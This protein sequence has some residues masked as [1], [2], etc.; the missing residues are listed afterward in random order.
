M[1]D[2]AIVGSGPA[3]LSAA[4]YAARAGLEVKVFEK[5]KFGGALTEIAKIEN[6]PGFMGPGAEL[7]EKLKEQAE[8]AG[9]KFAYGEL[10][11]ISESDNHILIKIDD[12]DFDTHSVLIATGSEPRPLSFDPKIPVSYCALCDAPLYKGKNIAV[13]G[14]GNSA[15]GESIYL[16]DIVKHLTIFSHTKISAEEYLIEKLKQHQNVEIKEAVEP[17]EELLNNFDG[18][19]VFIGKRPATSFLSSEILDEKGYIKTNNYMTKIPGVFA[20]GD[21]RADSIKQALTAA[22]DGATAALKIIDHLKS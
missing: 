6:F 14:G 8:H 13:V 3:A 1:L 9:A 12:E 19:F 21:V 11:K 22:A 7:A 4:I 10:T 15:V 16:A 20:A 18:V 2:L 17:T 5:A